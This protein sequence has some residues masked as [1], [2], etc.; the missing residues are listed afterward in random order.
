[1]FLKFRLTIAFRN[2]CRYLNSELPPM[3]EFSS[4][5]ITIFVK[6]QTF[7][8]VSGNK[9]HLALFLKTKVVTQ[10]YY[11]LRDKEKQSYTIV[12]CAM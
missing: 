4:L 9:A 1:M 3:S 7:D 11:T 6:Y 12:N 10:K 5:I 2:S 8:F